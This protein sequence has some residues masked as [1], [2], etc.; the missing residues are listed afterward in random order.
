MHGGGRHF[1]PPDVRNQGYATIFARWL[2]QTPLPAPEGVVPKK[3]KALIQVCFSGQTV[4]VG[5][6]SIRSRAHGMPTSA[7][8]GNVWP[9]FV[10]A[11]RFDRCWQDYPTSRVPISK[12]PMPTSDFRSGSWWS[13]AV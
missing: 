8:R 5:P 7:L 13:A 11:Q 6:G 12:C 3:L 10:A 9:I 2:L 1:A 4:E